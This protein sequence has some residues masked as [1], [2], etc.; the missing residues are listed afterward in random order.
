MTQSHAL[1]LLKTGISIF[2]TGEPGSGKTHLVNTY[3]KW[4]RKRKINTAVTASTGIA[5]THI[6]GVTIH[7]W[8]GIGIKNSLNKQI[9]KQITDKAHIKRKVKKAKVLIIDEVSM[10]PPN[11]LNMVDTI[12][13]TI[14]QSTELFGGLQV[15]LVGDFFQLPPVSRNLE[16]PTFAY[17]SESWQNLNPTTCY[18]NEQY[19]QNDEKFLSLLVAIRRNEFNQHH[20]NQLESRKISLHQTPRDTPWLFTHNRNVDSFN[21]AKLTKLKGEVKEFKTTS[22]GARP[23]VEALT[24]GC[25]SPKTLKLKINAVVMFTKNSPKGDFVNGTLATVVDFNKK[26][27]LPVVE[28]NQGLILQAEPM[29]WTVEENGRLLASISQVPLRLAWAITVHKSQGLSLDRVTMDLSKVFEYGQGYV[30]LSRV[31]QLKGLHLIGWN[32]QAFMVHPQI[33]EQDRLFKTQSEKTRK[34]EVPLSRITSSPVSMGTQE[35]T[36][37]LW[38]KGLNLE[39]IAKKRKLKPGTIL[40][41]LETLIDKEKINQTE[42]KKLLIPALKKD[43]GKIQA[44]FKKLDTDNLSPVFHHFK[45]KHPY[46]HLRLAR[47]LR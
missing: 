18:L 11:T 47:M 30:A 26:T 29:D 39:Q 27:G 14:R 1:K 38:Q 15:V 12:C 34:K 44:A 19:R 41:H 32:R 28:T 25:L 31:R 9:L 20:L 16:Q 23:L 42:I 37:Q 43:L 36:L 46:N 7:S 2:L 10:L 17:Q 35:L 6:G 22:T 4:L 24:R 8:S 45:G 33:L 21:E 40:G 13:Q 5:A 3:V